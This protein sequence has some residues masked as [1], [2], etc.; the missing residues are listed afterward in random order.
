MHLAFD[1]DLTDSTGR[2]N[3]A[4]SEASGGATLSTSNYIPGVLGQAFTYSTSVNG[5]NVMAN[6]AS[7]GVRPDLQFGSG[8]FTASTFG[9]RCR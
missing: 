7:L 4:T 9:S 6:Y 5:T 2:G 3:D 1:G 8:N